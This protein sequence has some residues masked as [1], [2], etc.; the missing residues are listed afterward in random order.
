M[1]KIFLLAIVVCCLTVVW[2]RQPAPAATGAT[3]S[4]T[5]LRRNLHTGDE[6]R[7]YLQHG[8]STMDCVAGTLIGF[9]GTSFEVSG[10]IKELCGK[11]NGVTGVDDRKTLSIVPVA[12]VSFVEKTVSEQFVPSTQP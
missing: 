7:L 6:V 5:A 2:C 1:R 4:A 3:D 8:T 12:S 10:E 9:D 11:T